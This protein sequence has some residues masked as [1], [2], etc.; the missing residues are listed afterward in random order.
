[1]DNS[2]K[3]QIQFDNSMKLQAMS[4]IEEDGKR[5][6]SPCGK[7]GNNDMLYSHF[8]QNNVSSA[9]YMYVHV[10]IVQR[11]AVYFLLSNITKLFYL[12]L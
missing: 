6:P 9:T 1:M 2:L 12:N 8:N 5:I 10:L 11:T 4:I 7:D 3:S